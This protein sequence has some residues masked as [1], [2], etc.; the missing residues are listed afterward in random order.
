MKLTSE[1]YDAESEPWIKDNFPSLM[2]N[3]VCT[4]NE[5]KNIISEHVWMIIPHAVSNA[6]KVY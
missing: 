4:L 1:T 2:I 3:D 5:I 6:G